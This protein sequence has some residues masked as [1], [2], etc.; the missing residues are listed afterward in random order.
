MSKVYD[1][2]WYG[3]FPVDESSYKNAE[4]KFSMLYKDISD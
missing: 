4:E 3:E 2:I 1:Y